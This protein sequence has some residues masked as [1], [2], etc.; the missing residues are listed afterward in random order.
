MEITAQEQIKRAE[1]VESNINKIES[2]L[3]ELE[4][5]ECDRQFDRDGMYT[6]T[7][8]ILKLRFETFK[9]ITESKIDE[10]YPE[11]KI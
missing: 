6:D 10:A 11:V 8:T 4:S 3:K 1:L 5:V 9:E 2:A 7:L